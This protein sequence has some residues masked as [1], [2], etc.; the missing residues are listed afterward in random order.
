[1]KAEIEKSPDANGFIFDGFPRTQSQAIALDAYLLE[2]GEAISGMVA[3]EVSEDLLVQR[4]L[5]RGKTSG[6]PDDQN[7]TKIRHRF[8]EYKL[9]TEILKDYYQEQNKYFG[10]NGVGT[11]DEITNQVIT[12]IDTL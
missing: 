7:E 11:I 6:R 3:L 4:I 8:Q 12:V 10:I 9:K 2:K 5:Q 1:L